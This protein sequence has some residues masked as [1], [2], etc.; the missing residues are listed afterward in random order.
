MLIKCEA[1]TKTRLK[2]GSQS[3]KTL[4]FFYNVHFVE[5]AIFNTVQNAY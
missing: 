1:F 5:Y 4:K 2:Q 3:E